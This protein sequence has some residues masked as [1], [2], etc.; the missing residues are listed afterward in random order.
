MVTMAERIVALRKQRGLSQSEL[1]RRARV[2]QPLIS[3][4]ENGTRPAEGM[5][6][7]HAARLACALCVTLDRLVGESCDQ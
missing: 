4:W 3:A 2:G 6:V 1:G 7:G 5:T